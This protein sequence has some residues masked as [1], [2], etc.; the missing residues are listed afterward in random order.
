MY[1][2]SLVSSFLWKFCTWLTGSGQMWSYWTFDDDDDEEDDDDI[3]VDLNVGLC[4]SLRWSLVTQMFVPRGTTSQSLSILT[5]GR[6]LPVRPKGRSSPASICAFLR[7]IWSCAVR[8]NLTWPDMMS[9]CTWPMGMS[10]PCYMSHNHS[11][12]PVWHP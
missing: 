12:W 11:P 9:R 6:S 1:K 2:H 5:G 7:F 10:D 8:A 4:F 3:L